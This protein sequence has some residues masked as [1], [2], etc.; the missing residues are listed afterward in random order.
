MPKADC[1]NPWQAIREKWYLMLPLAVLV[2]MLFDGFTPMFSGIVG[3]ALTAVLILGA[4]IAAGFGSMPFRV[5]FWIV[6]RAR[7]RELLQVRHL[8]DHRR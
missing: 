8:A 1:P 3:L 6:A 4:G 5:V 2:F 7:H